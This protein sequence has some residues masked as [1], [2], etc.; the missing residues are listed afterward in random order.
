[1]TADTEP[2]PMRGE[3]S[4]EVVKAA[5]LIHREV[6]NSAYEPLHGPM[7]HAGGPYWREA[8]LR[9]ADRWERMAAA[10]RVCA[11]VLPDA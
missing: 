11:E 7:H 2:R 4:P 5:R 1:M 9:Q 10:A 6:W 3:L 8:L